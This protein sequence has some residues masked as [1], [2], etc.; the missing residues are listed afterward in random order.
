MAHNRSLPNYPHASPATPNGYT[1]GY[2]D[3]LVLVCLKCRRV[4]LMRAWKLQRRFG[5]IGLPR[6]KEELTGQ[7]SAKLAV[8]PCE[9]FFVHS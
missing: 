3:P 5:E 7:C 8:T 6:L 9:A 2:P 1:H 4:G